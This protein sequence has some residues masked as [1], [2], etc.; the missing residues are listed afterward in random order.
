MSY[1]HQG[2]YAKSKVEDDM[3][4]DSENDDCGS[5]IV[6]LLQEY[7]EVIVVEN[8]FARGVSELW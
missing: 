2:H 6:V 1:T 4:R 3:A 8:R 5:S 7:L